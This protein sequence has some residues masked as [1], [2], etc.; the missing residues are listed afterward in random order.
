MKS[1]SEEKRSSHGRSAFQNCSKDILQ[2]ISLI[3]MK[4][5]VF[6]GFGIRGTQCHGGKHRFTVALIVNA[7]GEKE[8]PIV[9][10]KFE[11]PRCFKGVNVSCLP[12]QYY[13]PPKAWMTSEI[14]DKILTKLNRKFSSQN[15]N[16]AL[17]LDNAGCHPQIISKSFFCLLI[18][19]QNYS[20]WI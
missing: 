17:L 4:Q 13:S 15:R 12:V 9:I 3:L 14:M 7:D 1:K 11:K 5:A 16:V 2:K 20:L 10:W 6:G 18:Q 8:A 19:H